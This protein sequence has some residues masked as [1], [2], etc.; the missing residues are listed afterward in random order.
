VISGSTIA[1]SL[2]SGVLEGS[3]YA[4]YSLGLA[5]VFGILKIINLAHGELVVL[6]GYVSYWLLVRWGVSPLVSLPLAAMAGAVMSAVTYRLFLGRVRSAP[7]LN[8][9]ILTFGIGIFLAN[10]FLQLW[11]GDLRTI[12]VEW[13]QHPI[14][15]ASIRISVGELVAFGTS[16]AF[17]LGLQAFLTRTRAGK[18]IRVTAIDRDSAALAGID[19]D[20]V[21][22][23][24]FVIGGVLAGV[25]GPLLGV[26]SH[27]SPTVGHGVTVKAF[28]LTV[29]AGVGSMT[30]LIASGL[31][32]GVGEAMTVTFLSSSVRELFGFVL[33][34]IILLVRPHGLFGQRS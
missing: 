16:L 20:R 18:A 33:F 6:G 17:V 26:L 30:G 23:G 4:L 10:A 1:Q 28:I 14:S 32:I 2:L 25:A 5:F 11:S 22:R 12:D 31:I 13:L 3:N 15:L 19:V 9:L 27:V 21:D 8:T 34:L 24:A 7:E 29:L